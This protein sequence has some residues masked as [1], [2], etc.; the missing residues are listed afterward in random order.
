MTLSRLTRHPAVPFH[1]AENNPEI[2]IWRSRQRFPLRLLRTPPVTFDG[3]HT[4]LTCGRDPKPPL[5]T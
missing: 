1:P 5:G 2:E 3:I 4:D